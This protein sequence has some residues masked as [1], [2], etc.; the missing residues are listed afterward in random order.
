MG[1]MALAVVAL[2]VAITA[3]VLGL[4]SVMRPLPKVDVTMFGGEEGYRLSQCTW[5]P[6]R[7]IGE[8]TAMDMVLGVL[9]CL[10]SDEQRRWIQ[11]HLRDWY[12]VRMVPIEPKLKEVVK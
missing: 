4:M 2:G 8:V 9:V 1:A 12:E 11:E 3:L 7:E 10:G 5:W 6:I